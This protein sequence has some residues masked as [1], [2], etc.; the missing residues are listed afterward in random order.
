MTRPPVLFFHCVDADNCNAQ[1][2]N[3]KAILA[4]WDSEDLPAAA[5]YFRNPDNEV[6]RNP[7]IRLFKLP[8]NRLWKAVALITALGRFSGICYPGFAST[9]DRRVQ[10]L[11]RALGLDGAVISTLEGV[12][13]DSRMHEGQ[14]ARLSKLVGHPVYCQGVSSSD[15]RALDKVKACS[16][17]IIAIGPFLERMADYI[18][19]G[20]KKACIPLGVNL[21]CFHDR[22]REPHGERERVH[23]VG[24]GSLQP[25]KRPE[26]FL[27][28]ARRH[29]EADFIWFGDGQM[30]ASLLE[31]MRS[32]R[33]RNLSF[34]GLVDTDT[35]AEA[36]RAADIFALPS[37]AEGVPKVT[38]EAAACGLPIICMH[39]FE[40]FSV[41]HGVNG[42]QAENDAAYTAHIATM[43]GDAQMRARMG[44]ASAEMAKEWNWSRVAPIWQA[45]IRD[46]VVKAEAGRG[47]R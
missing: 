41:Q 40:P 34:P 19:P 22:D 17:L 18:W 38:Q 26:M 20:P 4:H 1:S 21:E 8:S 24:A 37:I 9:L 35:L 32:E 6:V 10:S 27:E 29:P 30:H 12:P 42:F 25:H 7:N 47:G 33:C 31:K 3:T 2:N 45:T 28:L 44:A 14:E 15:M 13:A 16:D 23:V 5:F 39:Y 11:R 43:I 46:A 36:F